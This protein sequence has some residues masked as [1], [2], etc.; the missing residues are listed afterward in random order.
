MTPAVPVPPTISSAPWIKG[1]SAAASSPVP[2]ATDSHRP[3][4]RNP[5]GKDAVYGRFWPLF[6]LTGAIGRQ[7]A[8]QQFCAHDHTV[9]IVRVK[10]GAL[11]FIAEAG[12]TRGTICLPLRFTRPQQ[13]A[14][15][16][17][18][19]TFVGA[20]LGFGKKTISEGL[21]RRIHL[22][23]RVCSPA[24]ADLPLDGPRRLC[25]ACTL[26]LTGQLSDNPIR[27]RPHQAHRVRGFARG[28]GGIAIAPAIR[29]ACRLKGACNCDPYQNHE[30]VGHHR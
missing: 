21:G 28:T 7:D 5:S 16:L 10:D 24:L 3:R 11:G 26:P 17:G 20:L 15:R 4:G 9:R 8:A 13:P 19:R 1:G 27:C 12:N 30:W 25:S 29:P 6:L 22:V 23:G 2:A 18:I 14:G